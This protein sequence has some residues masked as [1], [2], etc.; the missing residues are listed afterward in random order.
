MA[1]WIALP[2]VG[3][4]WWSLLE[5]LLHRFAFHREGRFFGSRH[6]KHHAQVKER[7]LAIA[8]PASAVFGA[9]VHALVFFTLFDRTTAALL[10]GGFIVGYVAYE[11]THY[12]VHYHVQRTR[13]GKWLRRYHMLHHHQ[14]PEARFGVTTPIW[15]MVFGTYA[16]IKRQS[17]K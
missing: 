17:K 12:A 1:S 10:L 13:L 6:L 15:D 16:P 7:L 4:L 11:Y 14:T 5:Y 9:A 2:V 8:P 3:A